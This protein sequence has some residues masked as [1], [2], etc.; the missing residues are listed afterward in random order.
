MLD[1]ISV[2]YAALN[3]VTL[4]PMIILVVGALAILVIDLV[5]S[6]LSKSFYV[7]MSELFILLS[8]GA[9]LGYGGAERVFLMHF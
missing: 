8:L 9:A 2:D 5:K 4:M 3:M 7:M 6:D 1:P